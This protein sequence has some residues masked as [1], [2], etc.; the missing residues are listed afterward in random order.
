MEKNKRLKNAICKLAKKTA[1]ESVGKSNPVV[2]H[3]PKVP[4]CLKKN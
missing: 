3:E 1:I 2:I 4:A